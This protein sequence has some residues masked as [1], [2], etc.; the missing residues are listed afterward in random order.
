MQPCSSPRITRIY[1][2]ETSQSDLQT[3]RCIGPINAALSQALA[4]AFIGVIAGVLLREAGYG[5]SVIST[6]R[7]AISA[8]QLPWI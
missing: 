5:S 6:F 8:L 7:N 2:N 3:K 4:F 1:A